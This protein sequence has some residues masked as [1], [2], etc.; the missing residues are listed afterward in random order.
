MSRSGP[1]VLVLAAL[2][3]ISYSCSVQ[4][5]SGTVYPSSCNPKDKFCTKTNAQGQEMVYINDVS[6][7]V[8]ATPNTPQYACSSV[9]SCAGIAADAK[10]GRHLLDS[11]DIDS[12]EGPGRSLLQS[13]GCDRAS[14]QN[15]TAPWGLDRINQRNLPLDGIYSYTTTG[16]G[17]NV[18]ILSTGIRATH[19]DFLGSDGNSRVKAAYSFDGS[20]PLSDRLGYGTQVA[21]IVGGKIYGVAKNVTIHSVKVFSNSPSTNL[22]EVLK[23]VEWVRVN[24]VKPAVV[25][26]LT[27]GDVDPGKTAGVQGLNNAGVTVVVG[28]G[29]RNIDACREGPAN[30]PESFTVAGSSDTD[31]LSTT[32]NNGTCIKLVAPGINIPGPSAL[33]DAGSW[34]NTNT[35]NAPGHTAGAVARLLELTPTATPAELRKKVLDAAT[36]NVLIGTSL[37][38]TPNLMLYTGNFAPGCPAYGDSAANH[39]LK[40]TTP[41]STCTKPA[42]FPDDLENTQNTVY[43]EF[44]IFPS[45]AID[46]QSLKAS[47][48]TINNGGG[49]IVSVTPLDSTNVGCGGISVKIAVPMSN[50]YL[51]NS[52]QV[53]LNLPDASLVDSCEQPF[54]GQQACFPIPNCPSGCLY[55]TNMAYRGNDS[56]V[57]TDAVAL[58]TLAASEPLKNVAAGDFAVY[59]PTQSAVDIYTQPDSPTFTFVI[60]TLPA[61]YYGDVTVAYTGMASDASGSTLGTIAPVKFTRV[62][63]DPLATSVV[64]ELVPPVTS[65]S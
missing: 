35:N 34:I 2:L 48:F 40:V 45:N 46:P 51:N 37:R 42:N 38:G 41:V 65:T 29:S 27:Y 54:A 53:C 13:E 64:F 6:G 18:Y 4:A 9:E 5:Q 7:N 19:Q 55:A 1:S 52:T 31:T 56:P 25:L 28:S 17:V 44:Q 36:S 15:G 50:S 20:N 10:K 23:A 11:M 63:T 30:V 47:D 61:D 32:S 8:I 21:G 43:A 22:T 24:H 39:N 12:I 60:V 16:L 62:Q 14:L 57:T 49:K 33:N 3:L 59:G 26:W 58:I